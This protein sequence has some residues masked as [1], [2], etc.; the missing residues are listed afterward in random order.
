[1]NSNDGGAGDA[2]EDFASLKSKSECYQK[3][4]RE[5]GPN[6]DVFE[7]MIVLQLIDR[8][9]GWGRR[10]AY[11]TARALLAGDQVYSG[12]KMGRTKF[13]AALQ[14]LENIGL[15]SRRKDPHVPDR[16]HFTVNTEWKA[17]HPH[18]EDGAIETANPVR[19][20][21]YPVRHRDTPVRQPDTIASNHKP[22]SQASSL[23]GAT[24]PLPLAASK[25]IRATANTSIS[26]PPASLA[27]NA[28]RPQGAVE[29][30]DAAWRLALIDTFPGTAYRTWGVREKA[31]IK[32]VLCTWRGDCTLP[33]FVT[34]SVTNWTAIMRKQFK[35]MTK[36]PPPTVPALSFFI[37]FI[38][39]FS[40]C[41]AEHKLEDWLSADDRTEIEKMMGRGQTW[42]Q[43]TTTLGKTKAA[44]ALR[45]EMTK[46]EIHVRARDYSATRKLA[47]AQRLAEMKGGIPIHP[48]SPLAQKLIAE[49]RAAAA[50]TRVVAPE[51]EEFTGAEVFF[52]DPNN[53]PFDN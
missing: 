32:Q 11:F 35:W 36:S 44:V 18:M 47:E 25:K 46:R 53:N 8:T 30:V 17:R 50:P 40:D 49:E 7:Q 10:E 52:V 12:I 51:G 31:Q 16:V 13:Y 48:K 39:Q 24:A 34:W 1:M 15:I 43:A 22:V 45:E 14:R 9:I 27:A 38:G 41:R 23:A 6:L 28:Q 21:D 4:W 26:A 37:N 2:R 20:P 3:V 33:Q 42:E 5:W 29:A 19:Q